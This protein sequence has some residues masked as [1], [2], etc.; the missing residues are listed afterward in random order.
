VLGLWSALA[1]L[2][3]LVALIVTVI[4]QERRSVSRST[5]R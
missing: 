3:A 4:V 2:A 5:L 1:Q